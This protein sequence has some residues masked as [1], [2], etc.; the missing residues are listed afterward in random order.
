MNTVDN[1][2]L[3]NYNFNKYIKNETNLRRLVEYTTCSLFMSTYKSR[4]ILYEFYP[5]YKNRGAT[6]Q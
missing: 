5:L 1:K 6:I 2:L 3:L 4:V